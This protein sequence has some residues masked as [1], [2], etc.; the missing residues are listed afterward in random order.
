MKFFRLKM[1]LI[2]AGENPKTNQVLGIDDLSGKLR[3]W[4]FRGE[5]T[6]RKPTTGPA[7]AFFRKEA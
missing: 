3:G 2:E 6:W 7:G 1:R 4:K 5:K